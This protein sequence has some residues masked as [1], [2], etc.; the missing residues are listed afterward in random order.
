LSADK[1][2][3]IQSAKSSRKQIRISVDIH[4]VVDTAIDVLADDLD[5]FQ[6]DG[7]LVHVTRIAETEAD[8]QV[9]AGTPTV[10][11]LA[12]ATLRERL[13]RAAD[14]FKFDKRAGKYV[15]AVPTDPVVQAVAARGQYQGIRPL[16]SIAEAPIFRADGSVM[17]MEGY[18]A[19]TGYLFLPGENFPPVPR[20]PSQD[21]ARRALAELA[22][23]F[24]DFP[25]RT[26]LDRVLPVAAILSLLARAAIAGSVP[27]FLFDAN[28]PGSGKT[29]QADAVSLIATGR[30]TAKMT[31]PTDEIELEKVLAGYALRSVPL[32]AFDNVTGRFGAGTLDR[33]LTAGDSVEL[34]V[35]GKSEV[36]R[37]KW[38]AVV[39]ATG[40]NLEII[41]DT[42]RRIL[43]SRLE[44]PLERPQD[45]AGFRH[46][47]LLGWV[48]EN[49]PRLVVAGL[50]ILRA[51]DFAGRPL[52]GCRA[53]GSFEE[54]SALV[55][56]ALVFAGAP[57]PMGCRLA[58]E[59][60]DPERRALRTIV[61][62]WPRLAPGGVTSKGAIEALYPAD[63]LRGQ[64]APD[65][66][67]DLREAIEALVPA[68]PGRPPSAAKLA[69]VLRKFKRRVVG[70][71]QLDTV[72]GHAGTVRWVVRPAGGDGGD[73]DDVPIPS[74]A[75]CQTTL[76]LQSETCPP[77]S[78]SPPC[79]IDDER[80]AI[81]AEGAP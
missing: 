20:T 46:E 80:V 29:K 24:T 26:E 63:R 54:W 50:T 61:A 69:Y 48:R 13:T 64:A 37:L 66:F 81:Q 33:V 70:K 62:I 65:G 8:A 18:D 22:E 21:D 38:R 12:A 16:L 49:R 14:F 1:V 71:M 77:S 42:C 5:V 25:Y 35:L 17:E 59:A 57:N 39:M 40:N 44:S 19:A 52:G 67:D 45:R 55:P 34:R 36:P 73:G 31:Y 60:D 11:R 53:W 27:A 9:L 32:I 2:H 47:D 79:E 72:S 76:G 75:N 51:W 10:R 23:V 68:M 28:T 15:P 78:P 7:E 43:L 30:H 3:P 6:R 58:D 41:G 74:R 4:N 56:P